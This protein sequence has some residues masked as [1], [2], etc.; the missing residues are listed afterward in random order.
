MSGET[1]RERSVFLTRGGVARVEFVWCFPSAGHLR[2]TL[3]FCCKN[4]CFYARRPWLLFLAEHA[5]FSPFSELGTC[6]FVKHD[7]W[8]WSDPRTFLVSRHPSF[9]EPPTAGCQRVFSSV[10][11]LLSSSHTW[12]AWTRL[13]LRVHRGPGQSVRASDLLSR[14]LTEAGVTPAV[15]LRGPALLA[16]SPTQPVGESG[17]V[18]AELAVSWGRGEQTPMPSVFDVLMDTLGHADAPAACIVVESSRRAGPSVT[19]NASRREGHAEKERHP[20]SGENVGNPVRRSAGTRDLMSAQLG[21][22]CEA[23]PAQGF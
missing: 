19:G 23:D 12:E 7:D 1:I 16:A 15:H 2:A 17:K 9:G 8:D 5:F 13:P 18:L 22:L 4:R 20:W 6:N 11:S 21:F 10:A 14:V 3:F